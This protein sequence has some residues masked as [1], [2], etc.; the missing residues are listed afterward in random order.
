MTATPTD[1]TGKYVTSVD[2][3]DGV[4]VVTY[5]NDVNAVIAGLTLTMTPYE[6]LGSAVWRCG[7]APAPPGLSP[8]GT[9]GG[10]EHRLVHRADGAER[11]FA[12][13]VPAVGPA[14]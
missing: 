6:V 14:R 12:R 13:R 1:T 11:V 2:V 5:G 9:A 4:L 7:N 10:G 8:L 3:T